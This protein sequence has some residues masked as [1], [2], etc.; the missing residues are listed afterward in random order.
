[1]VGILIRLVDAY[2]VVVIV[3]AVLSWVPGASNNPFGRG[4]RTLTEPVYAIIHKVLHPSRTGG[5]D[6]SPLIVLVVLQF[7]RRA[8]VRM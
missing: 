7:I 1:M 8:L 5:M 2:S 6:F 3:S 4:I